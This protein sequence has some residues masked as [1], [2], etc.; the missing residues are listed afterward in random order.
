MKDG[1]PEG[2]AWNFDQENRQTFSNWFKDNSPPQLNSAKTVSDDITRTVATLVEKEFSDHPGSTDNFWLPVNR[3]ES[4]RWLKAFIRDRLPSF[5][6]YQD[7]MV[8][9]ESMLNHS[10]LSPLLNLGLLTPQ[11]CVEAALKS[12]ESKA[13]PL[14][15]VE[16]FV[17]QIIGWREFINGVYWLRMP[18]YKNV[19]YLQANRSLPVWFCTAETEMNCLHQVLRQVIDLGY[20][21]HIQR[22]MVLGNF[23]LLTG[24]HP[25][26]V[27]RWYLEM[28]VDAFD[29]VMAANVYG[30]ILFADGGFMST[31]PHAAS[32]AYINKMSDYCLGCR[33]KPSMK[34]GPQACPFN[35]LYWN[36]FDQHGEKLKPILAS[37]QF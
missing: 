17:R 29:W 34:T 21:H 26:E 18:E 13:S 10:V 8:S 14:N 37:K 25:R 6:A 36:F 11:E 19:N 24:I 27:D 4:I 7:L 15:S 9:G 33:F 20:N 12:Y 5:G 32:G 31:K 23:L 28:Y 3:A 22:L 35:Y 1:Q 16:G 2:G 30:M